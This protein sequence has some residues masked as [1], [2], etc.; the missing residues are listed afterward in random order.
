MK[1]IVEALRQLEIPASLFFGALFPQPANG[2]GGPR[3][4]DRLEERASGPRPDGSQEI[5]TPS[6]EDLELRIRTAID[7][8][9]GS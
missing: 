9:L 3:L 8:A 4:S 5:P 2:S 7:Q 1:L 6:A